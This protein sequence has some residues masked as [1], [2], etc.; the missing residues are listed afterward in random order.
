[1]A[2]YLSYD[3]LS[4]V[5]KAINKKIA[6]SN[7][8]LSY[9]G[10]IALS[11]GGTGK[12]T[13]SGDAEVSL[14][15][16]GGIKAA[17][18]AHAAQTVSH[19]ATKVKFGGTVPVT[20]ISSNGTGH[21]TSASSVDYTLPTFSGTNANSHFV[22]SINATDTGYTYTSGTFAASVTA[23]GD[24]STTT[25]PTQAAVNTAYNN[26]VS[27]ISKVEG[28]T[29]VAG[30]M[31][32][33]G[34]Y[35]GAQH[36][37][38]GWWDGLTYGDVYT[39]NYSEYVISEQGWVELGNENIYVP[40]VRQI[41]A[42]DGLTGGGALTGDVTISHADTSTLEGKR[43]GDAQTITIG[44]AKAVLPDITVDEFGHVTATG[45]HNLTISHQAAAAATHSAGHSGNQTLDWG[46]TVEVGYVGFDSF[47]HISSYGTYTL[48]MPANPDTN[49]YDTIKQSGTSV[50]TIATITHTGSTGSADSI[51]VP[52]AT[53]SAFGA[54]KL[55]SSI[56]NGSTS[57]NV[58]TSAA[59]ATYVAAAMNSASS[60][61]THISKIGDIAGTAAGTEVSVSG[62]EAGTDATENASSVG[63]ITVTATGTTLSVTG[64]AT[65]DAPIEIGT[66]DSTATSGDVIAALLGAG[67]ISSA[68]EAL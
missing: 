23:S 45:T 5:L 20:N 52:A 21:V 53:A 22:A 27:R 35:T 24:T 36:A 15:Y 34:T 64:T 56:A 7:A 67:I 37:P 62:Q 47:G 14:S 66:A 49:Y 4:T 54:V 38:Q 18:A 51:G 61:N 1:M 55:D 41:I 2:K 16:D 17:H 12:I 25:A 48:T 63:A 58:P 13:F 57:G 68:S 40:N 50:I 26:L 46:K 3:G 60:A 10:G 42:G 9:D 32:Y 31:H 39:Y 65:A 28:I 43:E 30:A 29:D 33:K 19:S 59:V 11:N 44:T 6:S 8:I